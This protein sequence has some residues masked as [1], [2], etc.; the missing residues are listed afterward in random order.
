M[1]TSSAAL[2]E[3]NRLLMHP[4]NRYKERP[5]DFA[6]LNRYGWAYDPGFTVDENYLDLACLVARN[7]TAKD[8]HMGCVIVEG[9]DVQ[10]LCTTMMSRSVCGTLGCNRPAVT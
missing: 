4:R 10:P 8:G 6:A 3:R 5:P 9:C 1:H 7:S 2:R